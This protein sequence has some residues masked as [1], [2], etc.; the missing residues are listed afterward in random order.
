MFMVDSVY[1]WIYVSFGQMYTLA[2]LYFCHSFWW[3]YYFQ[4]IY[5]NV[6]LGTIVLFFD[7]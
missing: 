1:D 2:S 3:V 4:S 7:V 6:A 5:M